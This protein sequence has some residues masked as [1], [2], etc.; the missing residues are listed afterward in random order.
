MSPFEQT[1]FVAIITGVL[2]SGGFS[3]FTFLISRHDQKKGNSS[4]QS[5]MLMGL[6][7]IW[8]M[9]LGSKYIE[10]GDITAEELDDFNT[11]L[12]A[13]YAELGGN[14]TGKTIWE[15]VNRLDVKNVSEMEVKDED[16]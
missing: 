1:V 14:G 8:I 16:S 10:R 2:S 11:Y 7:H 6:A 13:P 9:R 3:F 5:K 15:R 12:Y 4:K